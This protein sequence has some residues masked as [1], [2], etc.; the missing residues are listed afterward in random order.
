[1][2][3][4]K[5]TTKSHLVRFSFSRFSFNIVEKLT[6]HWCSSENQMRQTFPLLLLLL[7]LRFGVNLTSISSSFFFVHFD[8]GRRSQLIFFSLFR[9]VNWMMSH[10]TNFRSSRTSSKNKWEMFNSTDSSLDDDKHNWRS[11]MRDNHL[12]SWN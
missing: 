2:K 4:G 9:D 3:E 12:Q 11:W 7:C 8:V 1:M 6:N 5:I 10:L